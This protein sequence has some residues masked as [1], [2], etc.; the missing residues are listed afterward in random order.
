MNKFISASHDVAF[1]ALFVRNPDVLKGF[2]NAALDLNLADDDAIKVMSSEDIPDLAEGKLSRFDVHVRTVKRRYNIEMQACKKGFESRRV[3]YYWGR[4]YTAD[5]KSGDLYEN[6]EQ[7]YSVNV[8]GFNH[9][10]CKE[11]HSSFSVLENKRFE[12][13]TDVLSVHVF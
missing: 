4:L 1:K 11:Y 3:M 8:L 9:F 10:D 2:L 5:F 7:T 12:R 6:L 13:L